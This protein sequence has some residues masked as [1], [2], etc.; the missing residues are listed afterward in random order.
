MRV[1]KHTLAGPDLAS[2]CTD[3]CQQALLLK[4]VYQQYREITIRLE[5]RVSW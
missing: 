4:I 2:C 5:S 3:E 1:D